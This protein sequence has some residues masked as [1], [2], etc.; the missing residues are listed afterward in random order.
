M[1]Q[2]ALETLLKAVASGS[3]SAEKAAAIISSQKGKK[4]SAAD[5]DKIAGGGC[6][7]WD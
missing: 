5:L 7:S 3:V 4:L 2:A 6:T 1:A